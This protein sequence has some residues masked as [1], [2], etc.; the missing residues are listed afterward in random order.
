MRH[1]SVAA[2]VAA[3][4]ITF[5]QIA[6]AAD[7]PVKAPAYNTPI[8]MPYNWT[9][10]YISGSAG[11]SWGAEDNTLLFTNP[12]V[13]VPGAVPSTHS[14]DL[15]GFIGGG[16]AGYNFQ[17]DSIVLGLEADF[18]YT[19]F[20]GSA[21]SSGAF[22]PIVPAFLT[23]PFSYTQTAEI[24]W[25]GTLRGRIGFTPASNFL[26]YGTG[27]FAYGH[28]KATTLLTFPLVSFVGAASGTKTGWT[29]GGGVEYA[30][31]KRWS[32]KVE[33]LYYDLGSLLVD[34]VPVRL[35]A[36]FETWV[37]FPLHGSIA[38]VGLN[39]KLN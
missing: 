31:G 12:T 23:S 26:V 3:S 18:S 38:R 37:D 19:H 39:Y 8:A 36:P 22:G 21:S 29:A 2:I 16:G 17:I 1:L 25:L 35:K 9:G 14:Y 30:L 7:L 28:A 11:Y 27:G 13:T 4:T 5:T 10:F 20:A 15:N 6:P 33:Y 34:D 24:N 32:V